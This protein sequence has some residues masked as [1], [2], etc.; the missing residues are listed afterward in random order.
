[1]R[2]YLSSF[3]LGN[4]PEALTALLRGKTRAAVVL[5]AKDA[6]SPEGRQASLDRELDAL[7]GLGLQ[8]TELDLRDFFHR[9]GEL[10]ETFEGFDLVW[11]RGGNTFV[12]RRAFKL[13][14][15][16]EILPDMLRDDALVYGG[17]S[18]AVAVLT[19]TLRGLEIVDGPDVVPAG[20]PVEPVWDGL[21]LLPYAV[22]PHYRSDHPESEAVDRLVQHYI[23]HHILFR[24]IRDGEAIVVDGAR[25]EVIG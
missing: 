15:A 14:G 6:S 21:G 10:R 12:L 1:M 18:A 11:V 4:Q 3:G 23:D 8:A 5:N 2:L 22:A 7:T 9:K 19:P 20:Y 17:F 13:S 25:E 16:D 24:A